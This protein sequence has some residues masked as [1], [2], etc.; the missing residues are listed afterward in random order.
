MYR[1][2]EDQMGVHSNNGANG[3]HDYTD[4]RHKTADYMRSHKDE[5]LPFIIQVCNRAA[6]LRPREYSGRVNCKLMME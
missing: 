6:M 4:L 5:L 3:A 2:V 1:A